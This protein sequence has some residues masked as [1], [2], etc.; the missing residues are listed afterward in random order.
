MSRRTISKH[1][2]P[3]TLSHRPIIKASY[4]CPLYTEFLGSEKP[5]MW[6]AC[7]EQGTANMVLNKYL[8]TEGVTIQLIHVHVDCWR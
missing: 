5:H 3:L 4:W 2:I 6:T 1:S 8:R 7:D